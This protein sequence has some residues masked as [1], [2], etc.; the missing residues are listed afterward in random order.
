VR[1]RSW[2]EQL[3]SRPRSSRSSRS[4]NQASGQVKQ[5]GGILR[6]TDTSAIQGAWSTNTVNAV[7]DR[8]HSDIEAADVLET[9]SQQQQ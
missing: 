3:A 9:R 5:A 2:R 1:S 6:A 4:A 8:S 7:Q